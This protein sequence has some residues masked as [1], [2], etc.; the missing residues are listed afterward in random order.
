MKRSDGSY[1]KTIYDVGLAAQIQVKKFIQL[2]RP[3][4]LV[5]GEQMDVV[6]EF[7]L[8]REKA[9]FGRG[10]RMG[11]GKAEY[12]EYEKSLIMKIRELKGSHKRIIKSSKKT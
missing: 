2:L 8:S 4:V 9:M 1:V 5:K 12:T 11:E 10:N 7:I 3:Y 6:M